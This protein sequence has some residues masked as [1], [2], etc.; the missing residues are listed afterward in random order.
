M[1]I[2]FCLLLTRM[3]LVPISSL[4]ESRDP[5]CSA[6]QEVI[7]TFHISSGFSVPGELH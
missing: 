4:E 5:V 1:T 3:S 6:P 2:F 7:P